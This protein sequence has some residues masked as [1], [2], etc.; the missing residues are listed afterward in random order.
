MQKDQSK[1]PNA[2]YKPVARQGVENL[3]P[4]IS[5]EE[6]RVARLESLMTAWS[7]QGAYKGYT[8]GIQGASHLLG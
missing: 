8:G 5:L 4:G 7:M 1:P 6:A 3:K 2:T